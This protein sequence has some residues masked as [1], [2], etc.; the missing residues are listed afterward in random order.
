MKSCQSE[1][2]TP[3]KARNQV[4]LSINYSTC[5]CY[6]TEGVLVTG[7][8]DGVDFSDRIQSFSTDKDSIY[9]EHHHQLL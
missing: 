1:S 3:S 9:H 8:S 5:L 6:L 2:N 7:L 4:N